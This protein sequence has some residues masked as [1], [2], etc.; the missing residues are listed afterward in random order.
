MPNT[1]INFKETAS[2][3]V[4]QK[5]LF[6]TVLVEKC[7][8]NICKILDVL[9]LKLYACNFTK[10]ILLHFLNSLQGNRLPIASLDRVRCIVNCPIELDESKW[11]QLVNNFKQ[12]VA[13]TY[14]NKNG[15]VTLFCYSQFLR[16]LDLLN[17][18]FCC[19]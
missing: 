1:A 3:F 18:I 11:Q 5:L 17:F 19:F 8:E 4:L 7:S 2:V 13:L 6:W 12:N 9:K 16:N 14:E 15:I 10:W